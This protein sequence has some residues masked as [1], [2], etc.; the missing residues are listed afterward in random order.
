MG[1]EYYACRMVRL[2][3]Y[4]LSLSRLIELLLLWPDLMPACLP[5]RLVCLSVC[6]VA[7]R[8]YAGERWSVL[9]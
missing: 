2:L 1:W 3:I 6:L 4:C 5:A 7:V 8:P 9:W